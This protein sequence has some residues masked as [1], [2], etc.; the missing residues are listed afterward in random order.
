VGIYGTADGKVHAYLLRHDSWSTIDFPGANATTTAFM[1]NSEG[2]IVGAY[3]PS[4]FGP[5]LGFHGYLLS[6]GRFSTID[7]P[8]ALSTFALGINSQGQVVGIY[9]G[10]NR[11]AHGFLLRGGQAKI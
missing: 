9:V 4:W 5:P 1:I 10:A 11:V 6:N 2:E 3:G 7:F 8:G